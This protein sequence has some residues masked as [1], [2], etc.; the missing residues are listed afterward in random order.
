MPSEFVDQEPREKAHISA[1]ALDH[2]GR[3]RRAVDR[4]SGAALHHRAHVL[5]D[6]V[7]AGPL[8]QAMGNLLADD[9]ELVGIESLELRGAQLNRL[10]G[11]AALIEKGYA[12]GVLCCRII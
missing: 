7:A 3:S 9:L 4:L 6:D 8:S 10:D 12:L 11:H 5:E 2:A 1:A